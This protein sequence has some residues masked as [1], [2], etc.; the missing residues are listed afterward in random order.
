MLSFPEDSVSVDWDGLVSF[1]V[2]AGWDLELVA[3]VAGDNFAVDLDD[4]APSSSKLIV[5]AGVAIEVKFS[6]LSEVFDPFAWSAAVLADGHQLVLLHF[7]DLL[8]SAL[9]E[10]SNVSVEMDSQHV[11][12]GLHCT[13]DLGELAVDLIL[14][15]V[16]SQVG[17]W[18]H[19]VVSN[20]LLD[21]E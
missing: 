1:E 18:N 15:F 2:G 10:V 8:G 13:L 21:L 12:L 11:D 16:N 6:W 9:I 7:T 14:S 4:G 19:S 17:G 5:E 3:I 20:V